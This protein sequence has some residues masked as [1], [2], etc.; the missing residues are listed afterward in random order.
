MASAKTKSVWF[1]SHCGNEYSKWMGR[2]PACGEWNTLT[3][4]KI[5]LSAGSGA[6]RGSRAGRGAG[7]YVPGEGRTPRKLSEINSANEARVSLHNEEVDRILFT[8]FGRK[9]SVK[10]LRHFYAY[11]AITGFF[12]MHWTMYKESQGQII[13]YLKPLWYHYAKEYSLKA[14]EL[15]Q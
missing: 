2:C 7:G 4:Q 12:Y 13:G 5:T 6:G 10:E 11:I 8:Y 15:Y 14:I 9:P 1:C 3:E